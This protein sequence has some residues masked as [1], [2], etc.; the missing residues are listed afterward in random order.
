LSKIVLD[1]ASSLITLPIRFFGAPI[2]QA[3]LPF[4]VD[5]AEKEQ[6]GRFRDLVLQSIHQ[7]TFFAY[8][9]AVLLLILRLP[10]VRLAYGTHN[11]PWP[12]TLATSRVVGIIA[13]SIA[14]Q[15][16]V[17]LLIR[18]FY[19]LKD[20]R[21]PFFI[22][23]MTMTLY[24]FA[25]IIAVFGL[26]AGVIGM[27]IVLSATNY[28]EVVLFILFLNRRV[29]GF[30]HKGLWLPQLKMITSSFMMAVF[31]YLPFR[32]LDELVFHTSRT[33]ELIMLTITTSTIGM[34]VYLYF[35]VL[36]DVR[37]LH[38]IQKVL[39]KFENWNKTLAR[40]PEVVLEST[41]NEIR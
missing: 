18:A 23:L 25:T 40:S 37:E 28:I 24:L 35:S 26:H 12:A 20:T 9:A 10:I 8:P 15:A 21:T 5:E 14:A 3:T 16:V 17:Q 39:M 32:I 34:L 36:F 7:I 33:V 38:L 13:V 30:L 1:L 31:L 4:L 6:H 22:S 29:P 41:E 19:A 27:A 11:F 2:G